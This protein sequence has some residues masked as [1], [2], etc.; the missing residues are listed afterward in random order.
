MSELCLVVALVLLF[1]AAKLKIA[2]MK[3]DEILDAFWQVFKYT[4]LFLLILCFWPLLFIA[5]IIGTVFLGPINGIK[6]L[7]K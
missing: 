5:L 4:W 6:R 2:N 7:F 3:F 1:F